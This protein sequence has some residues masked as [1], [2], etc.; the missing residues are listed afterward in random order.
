LFSTSH[1]KAGLLLAL[2]ACLSAGAQGTDQTSAPQAPAPAQLEQVARVPGVD[3]L[4]RGL[5][6]GFTLSG[7]HNSSI[8]WYNVV[9]PAVS[10]TFSPHYSADASVS[11]Y[12]YRLVEN[13]NSTGQPGGPNA[14]GLVVDLGGVGD[15]FIGLHASFNPRILRNTTTASFSFP[16]GDQAAGLGA[17]KPTFDFSDHMVHYLRQTGFLVDLGAG[18][19]SGLFNRLVTNN[20]TSV[21][22]LAHF[23]A[24]VVVWL[25]GRNYIQSIAYEQ[26]P[27][28][29]QTVYTTVG[30]PGAPNSTVVSGSGVSEDNGFTT[31]LGIPL[32]AH[33]TVSSYYNRS[34]RQHS[35]TV[36]IGLTYVLRGTPIKHRLSM[37]DRALR[38]A[39]RANQ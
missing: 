14:E 6:A 36:S 37:I 5:N 2:C 27:I 38:E 30:P 34:L 39:A 19:S 32:T 25:F 24:G 8:G 17:G 3:T 12:P 35:D 22:P 20:Y 4:L 26:L 7:V 15:T 31:S 16:T 33:F 29:K 1:R 23:Q 21:G 13:E 28:G 11:F 9:T 10:Y 18:D